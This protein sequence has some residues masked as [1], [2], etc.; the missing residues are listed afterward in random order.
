MKKIFQLPFLFTF[1]FLYYLAPPT[2]A[3]EASLT[4]TGKIV[5][6]ET[7]EP[8]PFASISIG[9]SGTGTSSNAEGKFTVKIPA[10]RQQDTLLITYVGYTVFRQAIP[11]IK[12]QPLLLKLKPAGITLTEV[13]INGKQK[14][15]LDILREAI[16]AIPLN[17]D[18][19]SV[20][21]T[22]FYREDVK[23]EDY[24]IAYNE[25]VLDVRKPPYHTLTEQE[26]VRM[27]KGRKK[28]YDH[29]R[30]RL[31]GYLDMPNGM[32]RL[33]RDDF[34]KYQMGA[35]PGSFTGKIALKAY[36]YKLLGIVPEGNRRVYVIEII[37][38]KN[39]RHAHIAGKVYID[40]NTLAFTK[41]EWVLTQRGIDYDNNR[42]FLLKQLSYKVA[43]LSHKLT[44]LKETTTYS[45]HNN[46][47]YLKD[48]HRH[49][50][51]RVNSKS[52]GI[53][54]QLWTADT[55][56]TITNIGPKNIP[57]FTEGDIYQTQNSL[58]G[59]IQN[60]DDPA[61]WENY[62]IVQ[63][64]ADTIF[65]EKAEEKTTVTS[66]N[67]PAIRVS[68]RTNG[69]TRAD[70]L[71]GKLTTLRSYDVLFYHLEV[72]VDIPNK[73][74]RGSNKIRFRV[75]EPLAK[76]QVDLYANMNIHAVKYRGM[77]LKYTRE[78]DAVFIQLPETLPANSQHEVEIAYSGQ[79]QVPN[80][81][82]PMHG[83]FLWEQDRNGHPW[84]QVACQGSG[85]SLWWP[86]KD[87]L[88]DEP[89]SMRISVTVP[90]DLTEISNGRLLRKVPLAN[91]QTRY[92]W[93]VSYPINNYNVTLN[94]GK[95]T[96]LQDTYGNSPAL[97]LDYYAKTEHLDKARWVFSQVKP[98]LATLEKHYGKYPFPRDG[99]TL[100]ESLHPME[101]QS[102]VT[103]GR[104]PDGELDSV[105]TM[106][107]VWH[108]VSHE[109]WGN[110]VTC[111][112]VADMWL[113]EAFATYTEGVFFKNKFGKDAELGYAQS[114]QEQA[115]NQEPIIG[116]YDVNHIFY[117]IEDM[118]SKGA[119]M[120]HTFRNVLNN[121]DLWFAILRGIQQE[122]SYKT[123][124]SA[125]IIRYINQQTKTDY[126]YFFNQYLKFTNIPTLQ[127]KFGAQGQTLVLHYRW[128][129]DVPNFK[130]PVKVT[131][132][133]GKYSF[134][135]PTTAW[136][137]MR[138][139]NLSPED[140]EVDQNRF[141]IKVAQEEM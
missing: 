107:L 70:T 56:I 136:Q 34:V 29:S 43:K 85:A 3:Q 44:Y 100:M 37:P 50:E 98:M 28:Q 26:Q 88:S 52:R 130:M 32:H 65:R 79:P 112:D 72:A 60:D 58:N 114:L 10:A 124:T 19:T 108:E 61:F 106:K 18:T 80:F 42:N 128:Q 1:I 118:Y 30:L 95:Y 94:I 64:A 5:N 101:H 23:L 121:D 8:V 99:F 33:L 102:A 134:I 67:I 66:A 15:A 74:I 51:M 139:P 40:V 39:A 12:N 63:P 54:N 122:F 104:L 7:N 27:I 93:Y 41:A 45:Y 81:K 78:F 53:H 97:T 103:F 2:V 120:L 113:H 92:E 138:L 83:G 36:A 25:S 62:N 73:S 48:K 86:N 129:T 22:A 105:N 133:A 6:G 126:N 57:P 111:K 9:K 110:N 69:F 135:F 38:R 75:T 21:L 35:G 82:I 31:H 76:M 16:A 20:Q 49:Y 116:Q 24:P 4:L 87:H 132:A 140:F 115:V 96:H 109:W 84:V 68:N 90:S 119:L 127:V 131:K 46:K 71:R 13:V 77:E 14:T 123:V 17:Y 89:D 47:W 55:D 117:N 91:N 125:D 59:L 11:K 137:T 141:Y